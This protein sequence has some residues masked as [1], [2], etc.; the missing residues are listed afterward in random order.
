MRHSVL[1]M[2]CE[3]FWTDCRCIVDTERMYG[4]LWV[5]P[6]FYNISSMTLSCGRMRVGVNPSHEFL[7]QH[8]TRPDVSTDMSVAC[9]RFRS[10][11]TMHWVLVVS[12]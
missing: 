4:W 12:P 7:R 11:I 9:S 8:S 1:Y 3:R 10:D 5:F 6:Y 2:C